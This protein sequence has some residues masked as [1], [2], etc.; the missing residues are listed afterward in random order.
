TARAYALGAVDYILSPIVAPVLRTKVQVFVDLYK[1]HAALALS[2]QELESRVKERTAELEQLSRLKD[3]FL[4]TMSH[5]LR[6]PLNAIFG[7]VT[8]LR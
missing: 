2:N 8:L 4:A 7:W 6:T 1:A 3:E 5:E